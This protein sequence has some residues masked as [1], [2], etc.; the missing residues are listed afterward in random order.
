MPQNETEIFIESLKQCQLID[1]HQYNVEPMGVVKSV[2]QT[3]D[4][5]IHISIELTE[6]GQEM[7][8]PTKI[9]IS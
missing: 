7:R 9:I 3:E 6:V 8:M 5:K 1:G 4:G 2:T